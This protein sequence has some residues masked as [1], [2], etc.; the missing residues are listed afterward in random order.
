[1]K[2][3]AAGMESN[4]Y[5]SRPGTNLIVNYLP[6]SYTH[7]DLNEL[8]RSIG[9][10]KSCKVILT[11]DGASKGFG[12]VEFRYLEDARKA[13]RMLNGLYLENKKIK[14]SFAVPSDEYKRKCFT[15]DERDKGCNEVKA[16][17]GYEELVDR[18]LSYENGCG[19]NGLEIS[20]ATQNGG[21]TKPVTQTEN[22]PQKSIVNNSQKL[23]ESQKPEKVQNLTKE[24]RKTEDTASG[25]NCNTC[26]PLHT[27]YQRGF[28]PAPPV[29][30][31]M[32]HVYHPF[33]YEQVPY[34]AIMGNP[35]LFP[36]LAAPNYVP[37][38]QESQCAHGGPIEAPF[39]FP[40]SFM[41]QSVRQEGHCIHG[42]PLESFTPVFETF[43]PSASSMTVPEPSAPRRMLSFDFDPGTESTTPSM[44][45]S[46]EPTESSSPSMMMSPSAGVYESQSSNP[47]NNTSIFVGNLHPE[48][49]DVDLYRLFGPFGA[50]NSAHVVKN[51]F[52]RHVCKGFGFVSMVKHK[53][54]ALA[55]YVLNNCILNGKK[56]HGVSK[57][58]AKKETTYSRAQIKATLLNKPLYGNGP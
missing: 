52:G 28:L 57:G 58:T 22:Y 30:S 51:K 31:L 48:S 2:R 54:A 11:V 43:E 34:F 56:L 25:S 24:L 17:S 42:G 29:P 27:S 33:M 49:Q 45:L 47:V 4:T 36:D 23:K 55:V 1:M 7:D 21:S 26:Y 18:E 44:M 12:F 13:L 40:E 35:Y 20:G 32:D 6:Y 5:S 10:I 46:F 15:G 39:V 53:D 38:R 16:S 37:G 50:V 9:E 8:F 19:K 3:G 41:S 14:V